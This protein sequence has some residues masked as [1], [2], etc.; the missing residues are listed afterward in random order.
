MDIH[1]LRIFVSVYRNRSFSKASEQLY[2]SQPTISEHIKNLERSLGCLLFDRLGR[3]I[4]PTSEADLIFPKALQLI[5][6]LEKINEI[7]AKS[8]DRVKGKLV[9][10]A[11]T[12][13]GNYMLP[14]LAAKFRENYPDVSFE[15]VV[16]DTKKITDMLV[17]HDFF[18]GIVGAD[19]EPKVLQY[20]PFLEDELVFAGVPKFFQNKTAKS[21]KIYEVPFL[22]REEGSGT[23]KVMEEFLQDM[24]INLKKM[25]VVAVLGSTDSIKQSIKA[26]LGTSILS[27]RAI[28]DELANGSLIEMNL[29]T[30]M[31]REFYIATHKKRT[32]P[33]QY[34]AF[35]DFLVQQTNHA[36]G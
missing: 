35:H 21:L 19:M 6:D 17:N 34:K 15:I 30:K 14:V 9:L 20:D 28:A 3:K 8:V 4:E 23:R 36:T 12:I 25:N 7:V 26:G 5:E 33:G 31:K 22:L 29:G 10:G 27:R 11:S 32:L 2:I 13:P 18:M 24:E 1:Q 16:A